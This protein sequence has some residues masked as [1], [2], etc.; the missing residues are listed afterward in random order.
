MALNWKISRIHF[1][2]LNKSLT[3]EQATLKAIIHADNTDLTLQISADF[4]DDPRGEPYLTLIC[5]YWKYIKYVP[6]SIA[7]IR[8]IRIISVIRV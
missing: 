3:N 4:C 6:L 8:V 2:E 5:N 1:Y 7:F